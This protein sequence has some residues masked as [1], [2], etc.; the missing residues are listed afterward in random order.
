MADENPPHDT[1]MPDAVSDANKIRAKRLAKLGGPPPASTPSNPPSTSSTDPAASSSVPQAAPK[2]SPPAAQP[3]TASNPFSQLG[4]KASEKPASAP[5]INIKPKPAEPSPARSAT[6]KSQE[7]SLEAWTDRTIS[8]IFRITLDP[9]RT[10]DAHGHRLCF[11]SGVRSDLEES[12]SPL[13]LTPELLDSAIIESAQSKTEGKALDYLLGCWKRICRL[14]RGM[15]NREDPKFAVAQETRRLCFNYCIFAATMPEVMFNEEPHAE[16]PLADHLLVDP[17][18]DRG[19][20]HDF[21]NEAVSRFEDDDS[22]KDLLVE[23]VEELSRRLS[24]MTMN[25]DYRPYMLAMR[26]F[27]R[28]QPLLVAMAQ[29]DF[30]LPAEIEA[31]HIERISL[32][33]PFFTISPLQGEV[34][35]NYFSSHSTRDKGYIQNSQ[36]SLRLALQTHQDELFDIANCFIK[37]KES[38]EKILDWFALIINTNHKRR[39]L[40]ADPKLTASDAFMMNITVILDRL[41]EP[42]MDAT[43]SK[44]DRIDINYFRRSPRVDIKDETKINADQNESDAFYETNVGGTNNFITEAFFLTAASHHYGLEAASARLSELSKEI[45]YLDKQLAQ[46]ETERHKYISNPMNL[47]VFDAQVKKM[48]DRI[49]KGHCAIYATQGVLLDETL[50]ARSMQFMRYV[51]VWILRLVSPSTKF[52]QGTL[53]LPLPAEQPEAWKC[54]PEYLLE[55]IGDN[56][57]YITRWMPHIITSTQCE[58]LM[59]YC[60]TFLRNSEYI[61]NPGLKSSLVRILFNGI[62]EVPGRPKGVLG[63]AL[64]AHKFATQHLLHALMKFFAECERDYQKLPI[65]YEIFQVIKCIWP[66]PAYRENLATEAQVNLDFFVQFVNLL[67]NDVTYVLDESFTA[68]T[69]IH[70]LTIELRDPQPEEDANARQEKEDKLAGAKDKAKNYMMITNETVAMLK[71]FTETLSDS[72]TKKEVVVRLAHMLDYNLALLVGPQKSKLKVE[73]MQEYG[74]NPKAMLADIADVYLNLQ[75]KQTFIDAVATDERSYR[76]EYWETAKNILTRFALKSPEQLAEWDK[77]G[78]AIKKTKEE[79]EAEDADLGEIPDEY[80]DP[81]LATLMEDPVIL[82][83]SRQTVDRSTLR[84]MLLSDAI[85]PF[86][87]TPLTIDEV[88]PND[89]LRQEIQAWKAARL[90]EKKAERAAAVSGAE[91]SAM[92]ESQ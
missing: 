53:E 16:N 58:E 52:P 15:H 38:R 92:D 75:E 79:V 44:V 66:N 34:A 61:R 11:V 90:A 14:L 1:P 8:Q 39:A 25:D 33:G 72:F 71:L 56:F 63:D 78:E 12:G 50:Q 4:M 3:T 26:N 22:V 84:G 7:V 45:K 20:C 31:P 55:D 32:L 10:K 51:I 59:V 76:P 13:R 17:E 28:Y 54:L 82:P 69:Q 70:D 42:F 21:L 9:G 37:T 18:N 49:S 73:N 5:R 47:A 35:V 86:N 27:V 67:L 2:Q 77:L 81:L 64:F 36:R 62:F 85:D 29:S 74:W 60:V 83:R 68:F 80:L 87:R 88:I 65:R 57:K 23:A 6:P 46:M 91:A 40:S 30:F 24:K 43:F 48:K 41:C 89:E 19:I